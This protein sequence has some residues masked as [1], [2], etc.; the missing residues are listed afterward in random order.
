MYPINPEKANASRFGKKIVTG[1]LLVCNIF[2][3][4]FLLKFPQEVLSA[5][6]D[7]LMIWF[8]NVLPALLPFIVI[9]NI[10][11]ALNVVNYL[12]TWISPIMNILFK[13]PGAGGFAFITGLI[14]G[15]PM[16][17]KAVGDLWHEKKINTYEAQNLLTFC[18][19][20]GPLFIIGVVGVGML[21]NRRI[22]YILWLG[23][24][25]AAIL[26]GFITRFR[27]EWHKTNS[28]YRAIPSLKIPNIGI[29]L[30]DAVKNAMDA[31]VVV[32][33]LI[34]FFSVVTRAIIMVVGDLQYVGLLAGIIE[35][36]GGVKMLAEK[37]DTSIG[38]G[39][40]GGII[41]FGGLSVHAQALH[42]TTG[43]GIKAGQY[44]L[45]KGLNGIFAGFITWFLS[46]LLL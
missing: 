41:A 3:L 21:G 22:G 8:N 23:H 10:L 7:G 33:G 46:G 12:A 35:V 39:L 45:F 1:M 28:T 40:I 36:T 16:G 5:S 19:N 38:L 31:L 20:A 30:G 26:V 14:S 43:T 32:G 2:F 4:V 9:V 24:I 13:L 17:A 18:N 25:S 42:F 29:L 44:I 27:G 37:M 11:T 6:R 34:I 15:Y